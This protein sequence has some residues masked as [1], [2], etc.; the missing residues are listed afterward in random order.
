M[1][2]TQ[3][4]ASKENLPSMAIRPNKRDFG[5][6]LRTKFG[7]TTNMANDR[8]TR[9]DRIHFRPL[10]PPTM[11]NRLQAEN[12]WIEYYTLETGSRDK[13]L[14]TL[15][16]GA[17]CPDMSS[18]KQMIFYAATMGI[19]R[20]GIQGV[21]GW[22]YNTTKVFVA[23]VWGMRQRHG[24]LPPSAQ[25]RSQINEAVQEWSKKDKVIN[26]QAKPKRSIREED[27][28]EILTTCMLPSIRFSSNFM[29][30]QMMSFMSFM[31]LHGTR[32]GTLLEAAGYVGTGQCLKWKDTEWVVSRWEDG[33]GLSI[34]CFVTLNWLKGQRMVDSEFLRTSSRSL[35]CHNM[36]MDW[37][38]MVLS[39]AVVGN[40]FEDDILALHKER[41][42]RAMPFELKIRDEACD[43]P[44]WLSKEK[45]EN[46][47]RM[48]TAQTMFRKLA[49]ILGWLHATF[50]SFRYAFARNMTDKISKTNLRYLMGH[51]IRSQLAFRQYQVPDRP[52]DVAA[53]RYQGEK[54][55]LG[56]SNYHSSVA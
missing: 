29:R 22:S 19:S 1:P 30:I 49:K 15:K 5:A 26:T 3:S 17:A 27:L 16:Q 41:P 52:V 25:V 44:V 12:I 36:H 42:S 4:N 55:S 20:L 13:A 45:A 24:C 40:V 21:T 35:G 54:E 31:F 50:R 23:S 32:P 43:R 38:L 51:S 37:Q 47:L 53:A 6:Q 33:V 7:T 56:T 34:E 46:P 39:L 9:F 48:A 28:N 2:S 11:A 10:A 8:M 14:A 18:V